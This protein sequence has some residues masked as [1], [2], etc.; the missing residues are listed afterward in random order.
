MST[1]L[2][3]PTAALAPFVENLWAAETRTGVSRAERIL[4]SGTTELVVDLRDDRR[5]ALVC[6][7]G[8]KPFVMQRAAR[9][10]FVGVHFRPGGAAALLGVAGHELRDARVPLGDLWGPAAGRLRERLIDAPPGRARMHV[11]ESAL[12]ERRSHPGLFHPG[13]SHAVA[14][15]ARDA[16]RPIAEL[17]AQAGLSPRHFI[18]RF[19]AQTGLTP[20]RFAR[21]RRFQS[22][23]ARADSAVRRGWA[24]VALDCGYYDQAHLA[25]DFQEFAALAPGMYLRRRS[26]D[27]NHVSLMG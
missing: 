3:P 23:I 2:F 12:L 5:G 18:A 14:A 11:L 17:T 13:V 9:E 22:A 24:H 21:V 26:H 25:R 20:K 1:V 19:A 6:G 8:T 10:S 16:A 4:P 15:L 27:P 7:A